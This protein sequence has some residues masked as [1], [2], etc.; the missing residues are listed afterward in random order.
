[1]ANLTDERRRTLRIL[2]RSPNGCAEA[3]MM[4]HRFEPAFLGTL[5]LDSHALATPQETRAG[6]RPMI[7]VSMTSSFRPSDSWARF[8][9]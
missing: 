9:L 3:L 2:A 6:S 7:V 1:M 8:A 5:V 4:A